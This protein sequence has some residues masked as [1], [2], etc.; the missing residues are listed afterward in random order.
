MADATAPK[1]ATAL[2]SVILANASS[3]AFSPA[4]P[5]AGSARHFSPHNIKKLSKFLTQGKCFPPDIVEQGETM[6]FILTPQ[7]VDKSNYENT[8][9]ICGLMLT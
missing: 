1:A 3:F 6:G 4:A 2:L 9:C 8:G 7:A 5:I